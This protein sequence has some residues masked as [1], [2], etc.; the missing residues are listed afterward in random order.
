MCSGANSEASVN[1]G[2]HLGRDHYWVLEMWAAMDYAVPHRVDVGSGSD[3]TR[4][5]G[6]QRQQ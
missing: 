1:R 3:G 2:V 4:A 6:H 5:P